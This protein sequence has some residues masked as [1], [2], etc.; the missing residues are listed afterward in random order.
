MAGY[1]KTYSGDL[2]TTIASKLFDAVKNKVEKNRDEKRKEQEELKKEL[3]RDDSDAIPVKNSDMGEFVTKMFG[4]GISLELTKLE[5]KVDRTAEQ[6]SDLRASNIQT[7]QNIVDHNNAVAE[8]LDGIAEL[9]RQKYA[10]DKLRADLSETRALMRKVA[11][12]EDL[13]GTM[14]YRKK[15]PTG[16]KDTKSKIDNAFSTIGKIL[17]QGVGKRGGLGKKLAN[18]ALGRAARRFSAAG[19]RK[20]T[21]IIS[22][23]LNYGLGGSRFNLDDI[24]QLSMD[25]GV[26]VKDL[27]NEL[28]KGGM[29]AIDDMY[30]MGRIDENEYNKLKKL[31]KDMKGKSFGKKAQKT[32]R[33]RVAAKKIADEVGKE[34][35]TPKGAKVLA[36]GSIGTKLFG[37]AGKFV[38]GLGTGIALAEASFRAAS[39]DMVGAALS[40]GSAIPILGWGFTAFDLARDL[41]FDPLNTLPED[42]PAYESGTSMLTNPGEAIL[43]GKERVE[44]VDPKSKLTVSH[45]EQVGSQIASTSLKLA[46]DA[47]VD[48]EVFGE[49][50]NLPFKIENVSYTSDLKKTAP[51]KTSTTLTSRLTERN[52]ARNF[53]VNRNIKYSAP[54]KDAPKSQASA[55]VEM[56]TPS[57]QQPGPNT[58]ASGD[59]AAAYDTV[60]RIGPTGD[61]DGQDTGLNMTLA[62]GIGTPIYAPRDLV[63]KEIGTDGMPA[64]GLQGNPNV[65][66]SQ[67]GQGFGYYGAYF[68]EE[69]GKE[70]EVLLG[71]FKDL[72]YKGQNDGDVIPAG[73]LLGYQ[74]ASGNTDSGVYGG[75]AYPHISLH[76]NGIGFKASNKVLVDFAKSL[77]GSIS[78]VTKPVETEEESGGGGI[79]NLIKPNRNAGGGPKV[80]FRN[81]V[82]RRTYNALKREGFSQAQIAAIM[83]NFDIET[84]GYTRMYQL[85]GGPGRGLAQ[86]ETPGRWDL[87][88]K[89][90]ESTGRDPS[91]LIDD[92]EGQIEWMMHEFTNI[93]T[94]DL[95]RPMLPYG[96]TYDLNAWKNSS[97][98]PVELAKNWM[99]W[100]EAPGTPHTS[101]RFGS[102]TNYDKMFSTDSTEPTKNNKPYGGLYEEGDDG[103]FYN[104]FDGT[105]LPDNF[106]KISSTSSF[107]SNNE[108]MQKSVASISQEDE[109]DVLVRTIVLNNMVE[110]QIGGTEGTVTRSSKS[111]GFDALAFHMARLSA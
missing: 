41:G 17:F 51:T 67:Q 11:R 53:A 8:K 12:G 87:A 84:M 89:W 109:S 32:I 54:D 106:R 86:W 60:F 95:G 85:D 26:D 111:S 31:S 61:T 94:D 92:V 15:K 25:M 49:I 43:H 7:V 66:E 55:E 34:L 68:F 13:A 99:N 39:G 29:F 57:S 78:A 101:Q 93:P 6:V 88:L 36:K 46:K 64:V 73:T 9:F 91:K 81:D 42:Q 33:K 97:D 47:G 27:P 108:I 59:N 74:G 5:G 44:L 23:A 2:T 98:D 102:A 4:G 37:K 52:I 45:I 100:Y 63:Y 96:Y 18:T 80:P 82:E 69:G 16:S 24:A 1:T 21:G 65:V 104:I 40:L 28:A 62:G 107:S 10:I 19:A 83:A 38:P 3:D 56:P 71:H 50:T 79:R 30:A 22:K 58:P 110:T 75:P 20:S 105:R 14:G 48:R 35:A 90:Y 76:V 70:Y 72:P 103:E 77:R